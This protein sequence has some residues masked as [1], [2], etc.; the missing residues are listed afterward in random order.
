MEISAAQVKE[1]RERTGSGIMD[2]K[3]AL[4]EAEGDME[5]ATVLLREWG[6]AGAAKRAGRATKEGVV[7]HYLHGKSIGVL[8]ELNCETDFVA[9]TAEFQEFAREMCMQVAAARP[10]YIA[11]EDVPEEV[12]AQEKA[13]YEEQGRQE[14]KPDHIVE[15]IAEGRLRK[16]YEEVCLLEQAHIRDEK[17]KQKVGD[18]LKQLIATCGE[19]IVIRRFIRF[20]VGKEAYSASSDSS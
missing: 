5:K 8:V 12:I 10:Q 4:A 16:F 1:L 6:L 9:N 3:R 7:A 19:N 2:C 18:L 15:K 20:E 14:G 11:K 13:I 17:G